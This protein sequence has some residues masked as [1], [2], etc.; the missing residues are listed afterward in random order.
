MTDKQKVKHHRVNMQAK[1]KTSA[2]QPMKDS[3][4]GTRT[5]GWDR[6]GT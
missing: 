4:V 5:V 1:Y 6:G 2:R 3:R